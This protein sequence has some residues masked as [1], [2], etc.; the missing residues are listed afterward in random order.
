MSEPNDSTIALNEDAPDGLTIVPKSE[1]TEYD[2][3]IWDQFDDL[4]DGMLRGCGA[5][6][7]KVAIGRKGGDPLLLAQVHYADGLDDMVLH[8]GLTYSRKLVVE[9]Q[10]FV[11]LKEKPVDGVACNSDWYS[12]T[13][14]EDDG[15]FDIFKDILPKGHIDSV[16]VMLEDDD[17]GVYGEGEDE[18]FTIAQF[19]KQEVGDPSEIVDRDVRQLVKGKIAAERK[20]RK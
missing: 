6:P 13:L 10:V 15:E 11:Y 3:L 1:W 4:I 7:E 2:Q 17:G 12:C 16:E 8:D 9:G 19:V 20:N 14:F 18:P 5:Y